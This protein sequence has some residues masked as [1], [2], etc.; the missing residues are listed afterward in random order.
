V[1]K[2]IAGNEYYHL[3]FIVLNIVSLQLSCT[4]SN[5]LI[6]DTDICIYGGTASGVMAAV[7]ASVEGCQVVLIEPSRWLGGMTGGGISH[8]DWGNEDAVGGTTLRILKNDYNN[9]QYRK[10][11]KD[12]VKERG[13]RV[14]FEHR[15]GSVIK[16]RESIQSIV[17]D[18]T[19]PD[20]IGCPIPY[21]QKPK[22]AIVLAK[23][24]MDCSYE[25]DLM[26]MS[27]VSYIYGRESREQYKESLAG[28][29][30]NLKVYDIDPYLISGDSTSGLLPLLQ[31]VEPQKIGSADKL[32]MGYAL[33][34]KFDLTGNGIP[35][36]E[37]DNYDPA[38][39]EIFR[40]GFNN[41]LDLSR[42]TYMKKLGKWK[43]KKGYFISKNGLGNT[44]R[45]IL[46][47][48][49]WGINREYPDGDWAVRSKIWKFHI[50]YFTKVIHFLRTDPSVPGH[51]KNLATIATFEKKIFDE[52]QG[53]PHQFYV[54]H[55]VGLASYGVDE[56]PY[57]L[58]PYKGKIALYG[59]QYSQMILNKEAAGI[60]KIPFESIVP[61]A[62]DCTNLII[63]V[64][65]SASHIAM[66]S[67][68]M[69]PV[70][71][72][73]GES[74]GIAGALAVKNEINVQSIDYN[75][76]SKKLQKIGQKLERPGI[77]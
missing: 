29:E 74:A 59:G 28:A 40:R 46:T 47:T 60:Y 9:Y 61:K 21:A 13:I 34:F 36:P 22:N 26:A 51:L 37:P 2:K 70:W 3:W 27:G 4:D 44:N 56:W 41:G 17:L 15:L 63:P 7:A 57:A 35:I 43:E 75:Q 1:G 58:I 5:D 68:R 20:S 33:R 76:L 64:C 77:N 65:V 6:Y 12:L 52:T 38:E 62:K 71:M 30:G 42:A 18:Y 14:I 66:T 53:F 72:I 11:F 50:D 39:F 25:G 23:V 48:T 67:I 55:S 32:T 31:D 45:S 73:L 24:F 54:V 19:P 16:E 69:E 49:I 10:Y 8:I